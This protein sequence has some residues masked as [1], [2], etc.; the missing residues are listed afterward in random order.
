MLEDLSHELESNIVSKDGRVLSISE[1]D[2]ECFRDVLTFHDALDRESCLV[3]VEEVLSDGAKDTCKER[4]TE[5]PCRVFNYDDGKF[6]E[7]VHK[8]L[9][10]NIVM[11]DRALAKINVQL[12]YLRVKKALVIQK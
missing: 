8:E 3:F 11:S 1:V 2:V 12:R 6:K 4:T 5:C 10:Q 7:L 9:H